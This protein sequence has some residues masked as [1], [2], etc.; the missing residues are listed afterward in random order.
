MRDV[1]V[2]RMWP[3]ADLAIHNVHHFDNDYKYG[4]AA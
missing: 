4:S 3:C 2:A 1:P